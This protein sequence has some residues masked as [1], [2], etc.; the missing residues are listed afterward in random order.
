M[1]RHCI[2]NVPRN[3]YLC[4]YYFCKTRISAATGMTTCL[5]LFIAFGDMNRIF[6]FAF[7]LSAVLF[8]C[9]GDQGLNNKLLVNHTP[10]VQHIFHSDDSLLHGIT[11]GMNKADVKK[12]ATHNDSLS[13]EES[14]YL[15]YEGKF[16]ATHY[17][18]Y[19]CSFDSAGLYA[20]TL[21]IYLTSDESGTGVFQDVTAYFTEKYGPAEDDGYSL[22]WT[23][24]NTR[25]PFRI[26]LR[27]DTEYPYGKVTMDCYD[28]S[29]VPEDPGTST[30][31][32]LFLPEEI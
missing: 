18:T 26:E 28:L 20:L 21:D 11:F 7:I 30:Q 31:D 16:D 1:Y 29:F 9:S 2:A 12:S 8:A 3:V 4:L 17:Y 13:L 14:D 19:E 6:P 24:K 23:L 32:S 15:F 25:R 27:E 10:F 22:T 5:S